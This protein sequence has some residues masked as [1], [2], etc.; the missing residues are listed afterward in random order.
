MKNV[1]RFF[2]KITV[3]ISPEVAN[4]IMYLKLIGKKLNLKN[5]ETFNEKI[6]YLKLYVFLTIKMLFNVLINI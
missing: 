4:K 6:N 3:S 1:L 5:P 2:R